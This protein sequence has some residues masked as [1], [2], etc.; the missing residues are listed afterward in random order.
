MEL[1]TRQVN[2]IERADQGLRAFFGKI[3][4]FM[5][6]GLVFSA[7]IGFFSPQKTIVGW[8]YFISTKSISPFFIGWSVTFAPVVFIFFL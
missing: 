5:A 4:N 8:V 3:Y 6:G 7:G 1:N 2:V